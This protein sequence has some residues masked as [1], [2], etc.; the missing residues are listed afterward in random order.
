EFGKKEGAGKGEVLERKVEEF[1]R[2][3]K[4]GPEEGKA[5]DASTAA[6]KKAVLGGAP[7][8]VKRDAERRK[9]TGR[10]RTSRARG[11]SCRQG[12]TGRQGPSCSSTSPK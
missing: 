6:K 8:Q 4:K 9:K 10:G 7:R 3:L 12:G 5:D 2:A 11:R 1:F